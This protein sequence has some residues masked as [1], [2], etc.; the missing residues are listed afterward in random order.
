MN[1]ISTKKIDIIKASTSKLKDV[2]FNNLQFGRI[3][4]D[5]MLICDFK[6]GQWQQP[7]IMPYQPMTIE[8]SARVLHYGQAI[9][10]GMKAYK[11]DN[12]SIFMF[13]PQQNFE[14]LNK[15]AIRLAMPEFPK[16]YFINGLE[17]L[18]KLEADWVK[19]GKGNSL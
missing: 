19:P 12:G 8:P 13:R 11:D 18:I 14:R 16:D 17:T 9:F 6:D 7:Q 1:V 2:D 5:N 3:F 4:T 15:S 10:E